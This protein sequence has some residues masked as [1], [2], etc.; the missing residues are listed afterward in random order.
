MLGTRDV[1]AVVTS[2]SGES[3]DSYLTKRESCEQISMAEGAFDYYDGSVSTNVRSSQHAVTLPEGRYCVVVDNS[4][5]VPDGADGDSPLRV[6]VKVETRASTGDWTRFV[7]SRFPD[8]YSPIY[9]D[10]ILDWDSGNDEILSAISHLPQTM[11]AALQENYRWSHVNITNHRATPLHGQ[12]DVSFSGKATP[13]SKTVYVPAESNLEVNVSPAWDASLRTLTAGTPINLQMTLTDADTGKTISAESLSYRLLPPTY[14]AWRMGETE[15][16]IFSPV[17]VTPNA[18]FVAEVLAAAAAKTPWGTIVGYQDVPGY[19]RVD[20]TTYQIEAVWD[21]L[22]ARGFAYVNAPEAYATTA[23]QHIKPPSV[24]YGDR[25]GNCIESVLLLAS[26]LEATGMTTNLLYTE[27]HAWLGVDTWSDD[28]DIIPVETT[29]LGRGSFLD[30]WEVGVD[31]YD[32]WSDSDEFQ[33]VDVRA[34]RD[35]GILPNPWLPN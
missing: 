14:F 4:W 23:V 25:T 2:L 9:A 16:T 31:N 19:S 11:A 12:L 15:M 21:A 7:Q 13:I 8:S 33:L 5:V 30:A 3:F 35:S 26:I 18:R 1:R 29:Q 6:R 17:L 10:W 32:K 27:T 34:A 28:T 20:V 24:T 22:Q